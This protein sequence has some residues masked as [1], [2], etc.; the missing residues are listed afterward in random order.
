MYDTCMRIEVLFKLIVYAGTAW[1]GYQILILLSGNGG[2]AAVYQ[3]V[4][5]FRNL[6]ALL[7]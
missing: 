6:V 5:L 2:S 4:A 3:A 1:V 7:G